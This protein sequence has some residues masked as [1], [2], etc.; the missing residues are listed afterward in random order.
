MTNKIKLRKGMKVRP[1]F[2]NQVDNPED[3][4]GYMRAMAKFAG[5]IR[6]ITH[7]CVHTGHCKLD[8]DDWYWNQKWLVPVSMYD[9]DD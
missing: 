1:L 3:A 7:C 8:G 4:P 9:L 6:T 2:P 5:T